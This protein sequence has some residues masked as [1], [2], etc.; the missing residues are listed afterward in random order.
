MRYFY[1]ADTGLIVHAVSNPKY[2]PTHED[3][4]WIDVEGNRR[5]VDYR[6]DLETLELIYEPK[7]QNTQRFR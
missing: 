4:P 1:A 6:V 2:A 5:W 7:T 3:Y